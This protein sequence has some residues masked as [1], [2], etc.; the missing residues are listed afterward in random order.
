M[1]KWKGESSPTGK[2]RQKYQINDD[3]NLFQIGAKAIEHTIEGRDD[4]LGRKGVKHK[5]QRN[6]Q[7]KN[8]KEKRKKK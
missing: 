6:N 8:K 1:G 7:N 4:P 5:R 3:Q 2:D